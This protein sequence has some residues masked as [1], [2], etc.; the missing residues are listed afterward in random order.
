MIFPYLAL[1]FGILMLSFSGIFVH[2]STAPGVV[3]SFYRLVIAVILLAPVVL[4][5]ARKYGLLR[6]NAARP[7]RLL[8][9]PLIG[10]VFTACDL[11]GWSTA[12]EYTSIANAT[13]LNNIAPLWV[14]LFATFFWH[15][16]LR[17]GLW[18]G[19]ILTLLGAGVVLGNDL[20]QHP[21]LGI[22]D[23]IAL[24]SSLFWAG[25]FLITQRGRA[26]FDTLVYL[27]LMEIGAAAS[28]LLFCLVTAQ[29]MGGYPA[30]TWLAILAA[31]LGPQITG[32]F[33]LA[34]ALGHLPASIVS[35]S[36]IS[37]PVLTALLAVPLAGQMLSPAQ[38]LGG[39]VVLMGIYLVNISRSIPAKVS[40]TPA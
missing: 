20:L 10:G 2:W 3:T 34:Y 39:I 40:L 4:W 24:V 22:G 25:Y 17:R 8:L 13:L 33:L 30:S 14:A 23:G 38:A 5:R 18:F 21:Q 37:Q 19:L 12:I 16:K 31:A 6:V 35:P 7:A 15:E 11:G 28:L 9:F 26:F 36:M 27:W 1:L 32:H 29:P